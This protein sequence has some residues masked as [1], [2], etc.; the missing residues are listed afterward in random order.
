MLKVTNLHLSYDGKKETLKGIDFDVEQG[1]VI[2]IVGPSGSGKTTLLRAI[3]F[4]EK[5]Q[6]GHMEFA[7]KSLEM[8]KAS[9]NDIKD[10]RMNMGFVFQ[11]FNLFANMTA[12]KNVEEPLKTARGIDDKEAKEIA[13]KMLEKVGMVEF[14]HKYPGELSGGQQQRVAIA[15]AICYNPKLVLFDEATSALDPEL[16]KEV[17]NVMRNLAKS[18]MTMVVVTHEMG[19]AREIASRVILM[20]DGQIVE[21]GTAEHM[22]EHPSNERTK[23]FFGNRGLK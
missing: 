7:G 2:A 11:S 18:G 15:R 4:L 23:E 17:L 19:F 21:Q 16:T 22:F 1:E 6:Q 20:E 14:M 8:K 9:R 13:T 12:L 5:S 3:S 10:I